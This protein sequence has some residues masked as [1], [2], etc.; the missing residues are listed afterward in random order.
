MSYQYCKTNK[1]GKP[2]FW[3]YR[4]DKVYENQ[5]LHTYSG[6]TKINYYD[7]KDYGLNATSG[8]MMLK[9]IHTNDKE[10]FNKGRLFSF[11][12]VFCA[13]QPEAK[14]ILEDTVHY[15][16][17][18]VNIIKG[19]L[20]LDKKGYNIVSIDVKGFASSHGYQTSNDVLGKNRANSVKKWLTSKY[21]RKFSNANFTY[22]TNEIGE[23]LSNYDSSS[24]TAK[25]WRCSRV[26]IVIE[27]EGVTNLSETYSGVDNITYAD[28][29][30]QNEI[31]NARNVVEMTDARNKDEANTSYKNAYGKD[32]TETQK[33][34]VINQI[35]NNRADADAEAMNAKNSG[36]ALNLEGEGKQG[37]SNEYKFFSMLSTNEPFLHSKIVEKL[38][39]FDP[40]F[41]SITPEGFQSRLTFL[42]QCTRQGNTASASDINNMNRTA[43]NLSFGKPPI[44]VL[45]IGD[46]YY[47]KIIIDSLTIDYDDTTWDLNDEGIGVMPMMANVNIS[48][49]FLGG[50]DLS[51]P[52]NRL[53]NSLSFNYYANTSVYDNR[54]EEIKHNDGIEK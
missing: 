41:H 2:N 48:F 53:Q 36:N 17:E 39:Y 30:T 3:G 14:E 19:I 25:A 6:D 50:S 13:I 24:F 47:T 34:S 54:A 45:R 15:D 4:C 11:A 29:K 51:G 43:K 5:V 22:S 21:G 32:M 7:I 20:G 37:Y 16:E 18:Q 40:A 8:Y 9:E 33:N 49:K 1:A 23:K 44:C 27:K 12:D 46:F 35:E 52:I 38:K 42:H 28:N 10:V 26:A 31:N